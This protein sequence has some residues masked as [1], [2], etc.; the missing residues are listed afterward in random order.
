MK[1]LLL[2]ALLVVAVVGA[3]V[4]AFRTTLT[5][6][7][8]SRLLAANFASDLMQELPDGLHVALCGAG[9]PLPDPDRSG[10]CTAVVAGRQLFVVDSGAGSSR[11][12]ARMRLPQGKIDAIFL[13]HFHSD[14]IDGL[15]ELLMQRWV[16]GTHETP[17]PIHGPTGVESVVTGLN[18]A[19]RQ[20]A[21]Y[22]TAHHGE[23][24][25]PSGGEGA[26]AVPFPTPPGG[27]GE[28]LI[29]DAGVKVTA[30][31]VDHAPVAPAVGYRVD[32]AGRSL[33]ISGDT[34]KSANLEAF[35]KGADLLIH[36]ALSPK[37]VNALPEVA[38]T[39]GRDNLGKI[40]PDILD[41]HASP[42]DAAESAQTAG[43]DHLLD[44]HVV[45]PL[46]IPTM[47]GIFLE[48]T[49][50]AFDGAITL[51]QDGTMILMEANGDGIEVE[52][53]L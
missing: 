14:H 1:R 48:G 49:S 21:A 22:R 41:Y 20:D 46:I 29:D 23:E 38:R 18:E 13:T 8:M 26:V 51:G 39:A 53:L 10:P 25:V 43:V 9:S 15:G 32:Y 35:A 19:Y 3:G 5:L 40:T 33:V 47:T 42:V 6:R 27:H 28:V 12:L 16:N 50:D 24:T 45:P 34:V 37:R 4:Y 30:F 52:E 2:G 36:E 7:L 31:L 17:T 44:Y 11:V